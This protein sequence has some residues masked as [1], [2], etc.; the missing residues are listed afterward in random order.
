M[1]FY[2]SVFIEVFILVVALSVDAFLASFAY[3]VD[4]IRIPFSS[5][6]VI[7]SMSS[8]ILGLFLFAGQLAKLWIPPRLAA[9]ISFVLLFMVGFLK[10]F[11]GLMKMIIRQYSL[12]EKKLNF[13][14]FDFKFI[15]TVYA[16]PN[17]ADT[18]KG[19]ILSAK[20]AISLGI[21]LSI[22]SAAAGLGAGV[23]SM[24]IF[25]SIVLAL[26]TS[27]GAVFLG[28]L[29]GGVVAKRFSLDFS[30]VSG[31]LLILLAFSKLF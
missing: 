25:L 8:G 16:D 12:L 21:A 17:K 3:G 23:A 10:L 24:P 26:G 6:L 28:A 5:I 31:V 13:H 18:D 29:A 4:K 15:L 1:P 22:D 2:F 9:E 27:I 11:D 7:S 14:I 19:G 20:E 30:W